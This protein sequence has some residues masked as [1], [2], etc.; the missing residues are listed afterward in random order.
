MN[1]SAQVLIKYIK[2]AL[3]YLQEAINI[4]RNLL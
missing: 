4:I 1:E 2:I 3:T